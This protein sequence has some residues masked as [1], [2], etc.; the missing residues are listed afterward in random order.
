[1]YALFTSPLV[2]FLFISKFKILYASGTVIEVELFE[3]VLL[4]ENLPDLL[5]VWINLKSVSI[6]KLINLL[7]LTKQD[8]LKSVVKLT[9]IF[10]QLQIELPKL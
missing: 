10:H 2:F 3:F 8:L 7:T 1:M 4:N 6:E 5:K 9:K